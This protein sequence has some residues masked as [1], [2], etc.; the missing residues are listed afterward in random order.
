MYIELYLVV[1]FLML[2]PYA[3]YVLTI[4]VSIMILCLLVVS[5]IQ[6]SKVSNFVFKKCSRASP[7]NRENIKVVGGRS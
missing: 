6:I 1:S 2:M 3:P 4:L 5:F 7:K